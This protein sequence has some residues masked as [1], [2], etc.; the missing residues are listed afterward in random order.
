LP[1]EPTFTDDVAARR[2]L[3]DAADLVIAHSEL[4]LQG[5][6]KIGAEPKRSVII[7]HGSYVGVYPVTNLD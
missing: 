4:T 3:V 2:K 6:R 1:H 7:P 5:L